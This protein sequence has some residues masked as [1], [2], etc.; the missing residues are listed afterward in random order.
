MTS[1]TIKYPF[2]KAAL[3]FV[4]CPVATLAQEDN[5]SEWEQATA[6]CTQE[7]D[8]K[9]ACG[10]TAVYIAEEPEMVS[11]D[12][13]GASVAA[14]SGEGFQDYNHEYAYAIITL[15]ET[16]S[17]S[18]FRDVEKG[19]AFIN[20][21]KIQ[22]RLY[23]YDHESRNG[24]QLETLMWFIPPKA[25]L[26]VRSAESF[27][28]EFGGAEFGIITLLPQFRKMLQWIDGI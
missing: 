12:N 13:A 16:R 23:S 5:L 15:I 25:I 9:F 6:N 19:R 7:D 1:N 3:V 14:L 10:P 17:G 28:L 20:G 22:M 21:E 27:R 2:F 8:R 18:G 24:V 11:I 4:L 26:A